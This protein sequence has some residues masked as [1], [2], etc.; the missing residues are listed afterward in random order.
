M[1][2][3]GCVLDL[4]L[5]DE[6][7]TSA[8]D[9]SRY[10]NDGALTGCKWVEN[11]LVFNGSTDYVNC[12]NDASLDITDAITISALLKT[13]DITQTNGYFLSKDNGASFRA[14][15][16][17]MES[18]RVRFLLWNSGSTLVSI[19][20][21]AGAISN[22]SWFYIVAV[23]DGGNNIKMYING[24][25]QTD[26]NTIGDIKT[27]VTDLHIGNMTNFYFKGSIDQPR[28]Y[29]RALSAAE[30]YDYYESTKHRY[31]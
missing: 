19:Y 15:S 21:D 1:T 8:H 26:T 18:S 28:I 11:G 7:G 31:K 10:G 2:S 16:L 20:S 27:V 12:G 3:K 17:K 25:L 14:Y 9:Y 23:K 13:S 22:D 30:I 5:D 24:V 29:N 4:R 6:S